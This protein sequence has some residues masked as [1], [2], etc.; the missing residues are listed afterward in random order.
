MNW[1]EQELEDY[2]RRQGKPDKGVILVPKVKES[3]IQRSIKQLLQ[4]YKFFVVKIQQGA[5]SEP[6]IPDLWCIGLNKSRETIQAW[7]EVKTPTGRLS[8]YQEDFRTEV[9][10]RGGTY[11]VMRSVDDCMSWLR[12]VGA[13]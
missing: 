4:T 10:M 6:G 12:D 3:E 13:A 8:P 7:I 9:D 1:T 5:L 11:L 2:K